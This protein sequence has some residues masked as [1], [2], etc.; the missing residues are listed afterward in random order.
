MIQKGLTIRFAEVGKIKIG[1]LGE[2]RTS[3]NNKEFRLPVRFNH[4]IV[5]TTEKG[6]DGNF[7]IDTAIMKKLAPEPKEIPIRLPFDDIDMNFYT[8]F[9]YYHGAKRVCWGDGRT[10]TRRVENESEKI[11]ECNP[12]KCPYLQPDENG[13]TRCKPSGILSCHIPISMEVGGI[14]RFR[15]HSWNSVSNILA[16]LQY[17]AENTN[18]VLQGLPLKLKFLKKSTQEHGNVNVVTVV[19]DGIE[20][21]KM[22]ELALEEYKN[23]LEL[24]IDMQQLE[25]KAKAIGFLDDK[26]DPEDVEAEFY[27][28]VEQDKNGVSADQAMGKLSE[29]ESP[30]EQEEKKAD[31]VIESEEQEELL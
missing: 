13:Q 16:A 27:P 21:A 19:L 17:F 1:G 23:R 22:R 26:D 10:A 11:I 15:T 20:L 4:F 5:T 28:V 6:P 14:Y 18:G 2:K 9:S 3:K 30:P 29:K 31:T 25:N 24:N 12:Q 7:M 8:T